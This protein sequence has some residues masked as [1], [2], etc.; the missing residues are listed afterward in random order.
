MEEP[1]MFSL[2]FRT[3]PSDMQ[4]KAEPS[5]SCPSEVQKK[6][7]FNNL[8]GFRCEQGKGA[9]RQIDIR[10]HTEKP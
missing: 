10:S 4:V 3:M 9:T 8:V 5:M 7:E 1:Y 2:Y 6:H